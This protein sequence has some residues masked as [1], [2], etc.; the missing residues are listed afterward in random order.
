MIVNEPHVALKRGTQEFRK[1]SNA[2]AQKKQF[3]SEENLLHL[4]FRY[5]AYRGERDEAYFLGYNALGL[6]KPGRPRH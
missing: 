4:T 5:L 1:V 2:E 3:F 6:P